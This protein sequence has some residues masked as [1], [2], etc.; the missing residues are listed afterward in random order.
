MQAFVLVARINK[1][2]QSGRTLLLHSYNW[3]TD[4][5][6]KALEAIMQGPM[7]VTSG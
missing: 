3:E 1:T 7:V 4:K 6:G 2:Q 5:S